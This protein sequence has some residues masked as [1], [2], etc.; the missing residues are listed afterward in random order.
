MFGQARHFMLPIEHLRA[1]VNS[2]AVTVTTV[3]GWLE[4]PN[5][6]LLL[7]KV[8]QVAIGK[9][10]VLV[11]IQEKNDWAGVEELS[12]QAKIGYD[13]NGL[14]VYVKVHDAHARLPGDWPGI[15]GS[16]VEFFFDF[17]AADGGLGEL[18]YDSDVHQIVVWPAIKAGQ[19][20]AVWHA[21]G[22]SSPLL[23]LSVGGVSLDADNYWLIL[24]IPAS[25]I[26]RSLKTGMQMGFDV[27]INGPYPQES[28]RKSQ[29]MMFG[30]SSNYS[31]ASRFGDALL[32]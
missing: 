18:S 3:I 9:P 17:R 22:S 19:N 7:N 14:L 10:D 25:D 29:L 12:G 11:S 32:D 1:G 28:G 16:Y 27:G 2:I 24:R 23:N 26:G 21:S 6:P 20:P 30:T 31:D 8:D 4:P 15:E 13:D 5:G